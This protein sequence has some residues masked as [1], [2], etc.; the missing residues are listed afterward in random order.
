MAQ[1][2]ISQLE[3]GERKAMPSTVRKL[4]DALGIDI[5]LLLVDSATA[6][7]VDG[8]VARHLSR[9]RNEHKRAAAKYQA[10]R[11]FFGFAEKPGDQYETGGWAEA[12]VSGNLVVVDDTLPKAHRD[13][14]RV[15]REGAFLRYEV[16]PSLLSYPEDLV[17]ARSRLASSDPKEIVEAAQLV[18]RRAKTIVEEYDSHLQ[19]FYRIPERYFADPHASNRIWKLEG[20]LSD[21]CVA[22]TEAVQKL[23]DLYQ[24]C[25]D[26]LERQII[27]MRKEGDELEEYVTRL[28][29]GK[30]ERES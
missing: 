3:R 1:N 10:E 17:V 24:E 16:V 20:A 21:K 11:E 18:L 13:V 30:G 26:T 12:F 6:G 14:I 23:V 8:R 22:A 2:T 25:L 28:S 4:A 19:S 5:P 7:E 27:E 15:H 29:T 9:E